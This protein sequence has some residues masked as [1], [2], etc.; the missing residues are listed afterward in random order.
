ERV[1]AKGQPALIRACAANAAGLLGRGS[2]TAMAVVGEA[3]QTAPTELTGELALSLGLMGRS[4]LAEELL[5][6]ESRAGSSYARGR[7]VRALGLL[8]DPKAIDPLVKRL[9][10]D[11]AAPLARMDAAIALGLMGSPMGE[12]P[13]YAL[14][15]DFNF[16][17]TTHVTLEILQQS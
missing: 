17:A 5:S 6:I 14:T 8:A 3:L 7:I 1:R 11:A 9:R 2:V 13:L 15:R 10:D 12:D 16:F 4:T